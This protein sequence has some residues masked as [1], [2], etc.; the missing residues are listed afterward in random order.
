MD[1]SWPAQIPPE[2]VGRAFFD[3][4][5]EKLGKAATRRVVDQWLGGAVDRGIIRR[6]GHTRNT[7][8][9]RVIPS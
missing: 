6:H 7:L 1:D 5:A 2:G 8:W 9:F 3:D 4:L